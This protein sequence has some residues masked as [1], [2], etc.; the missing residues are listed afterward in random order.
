M[1]GALLLAFLLAGCV[2]APAPEL[3]APPAGPVVGAVGVSLMVGWSADAEHLDRSPEVSWPTGDAPWSFASRINA[4]ARENEA[5]GGAHSSFFVS[6]ANALRESTFVLVGFVDSSLCAGMT[7]ATDGQPGEATFEDDLRAGVRALVAR[8]IEV[9][10][11]SPPNFASMAEAARAKAPL[12]ADHSYFWVMGQQCGAE[13]GYAA[14]A[15]ATNAIIVRVAQEEG[16]MHDGGAVT[17]LTWTPEMISDV[18]GFH[19]SQAGNE[20][21]AA[22]VWEAYQVQRT[23]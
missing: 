12:S 11:I 16:A 8:G 3:E 13:P 6:Q 23:L 1:R 19:A 21:I 14:N 20:A 10:L 5:Q 7:F 9:M 15:A 2:A 22:A 17:K 4:S 18:D